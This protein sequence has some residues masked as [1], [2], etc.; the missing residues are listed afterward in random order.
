M[1]AW[2][3]WTSDRPIA[4]HW[5]SFPSNLNHEAWVLDVPETLN[6]SKSRLNQHAPKKMG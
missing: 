6:C 2:R 4:Q 5:D 1:A 3:G